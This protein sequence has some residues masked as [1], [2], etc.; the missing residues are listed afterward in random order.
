MN[1]LI[2]DCGNDSS[3]SEFQPTFST[4]STDRQC[5]SAILADIASDSRA[6]SERLNEFCSDLQ[7]DW[8]QYDQTISD[9]IRETKSPTISEM[10]SISKHHQTLSSEISAVSLTI[11]S[12]APFLMVSALGDL[13][14]LSHRIYS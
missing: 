14:L 7:L 12:P 10:I 5:L 13:Y 9:E 3:K 2:D 1:I 4:L 8:V 6:L 11:A